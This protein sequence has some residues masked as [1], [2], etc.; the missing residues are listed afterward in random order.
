MKLITELGINRN[1]VKIW[2]IVGRSITRIGTK[3]VSKK[4]IY[5]EDGDVLP[6]RE[7]EKLVACEIAMVD[8]SESIFV[9]VSKDSGYMF[10]P[11][12]KGYKYY[13]EMYDRLQKN[14]GYVWESEIK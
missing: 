4:P 6:L 7:V 3:A 14:D 2:N 5:A 10:N 1:K 13:R 8:N 9:Y 11:S 12:S